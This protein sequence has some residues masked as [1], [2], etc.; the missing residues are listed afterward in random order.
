MIILSVFLTDI[1]ENPQRGIWRSDVQFL[2]VR[3]QCKV[4]QIPFTSSANILALFLVQL[5]RKPL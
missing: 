1:P 3:L 5:T 4:H 2:Q